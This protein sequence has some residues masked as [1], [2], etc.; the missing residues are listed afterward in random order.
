MP[1]WQAIHLG[2]DTIIDPTE[3]N[4]LAEN[5]SALVGRTYG[6]PGN[7]LATKIVTVTANDTNNNDALDQ[8]NNVRNETFVTDIGAGPQSFV[9]DAATAYSATITYVNGTTATATVVIFQDVAG[10][11]FLAPGLSAGANAPLTA[12][13]IQSITL[14]G[15]V[16][17]NALGLAVNRP[18]NVFLPC[19]VAGTRIGTPAG[20]MPVERLRPGDLV[21]TRDRGAQPLVW[22]GS[23][24]VAGVGR[25]APIRFARG[26][27]G[28][29]RPLFVSPQHRM[30]VTGWRAELFFGQEE[31]LAAARHLVDGK[32]VVA[33]PCATV[34]YHHIMFDRHEIVLAEGALTE[35][36]HPGDHAMMADPAIRGEILSL[37]PEL[38][39]NRAAM[40]TARA[41]LR[42]PEARV[43]AAA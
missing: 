7:A 43:L 17:N 39:R 29:S 32:A 4:T 37:F 40:P 36:F 42:G 8:N 11:T 9:F 1:T 22:T 27:L 3:G 15:V 19:F 18:V 34:S 38:D 25:F 16:T 13:P 23:R 33:V 41:V 24:S 5:A 26:V 2:F 28:N 6:G 12:L 10:R 14:T 21:L 20:P 30:L 35:S 31:V